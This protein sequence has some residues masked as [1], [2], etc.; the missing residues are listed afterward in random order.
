[1]AAFASAASARICDPMLPE[2]AVSFATSASEAAHVVSGFAVAYGLLQ[3]FFGPLGDRVGKYR[4]IALATLLSA[5]G[6]LAATLAWSLNSLVAARILTGATAA[7]IIPLSMAWI[8]DT[9][10]YEDRQATLA[11]FLGGQILGVVGGQFIG[12]LFADTLGWRFAFAFLALIYLVIGAAVWRESRVNAIVRQTVVVN[13]ASAGVVPQII[14]VLKMPWARVVL[15]VVFLEGML[16]FGPLAFVPSFLHGSFGVSLTLAGLLMTAFGLGGLTY[17]AFARRLVRRLGEVGLAAMGGVLL[18]AAWSLLALEKGWE[19]TPLAT[20]LIGLG[21]YS[22][23]N[24]LQTNATQMAPLVRGTAVSLFASALFIGQS[25]G[26]W[27][28]AQVLTAADG[29]ALFAGAALLTP[30]VAAV[31][32]ALLSRHHRAN[33]ARPA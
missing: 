3:A 6:A 11:R 13:K 31:F 8:G 14:L 19:W 26:V 32:A 1:M 22:L 21:Y 24:T 30:V 12:G 33:A 2:L 4:L 16:V 20:Y 5:L 9:V 17:I 18:A 10:A 27:T 28:A 7:G 23:H 25:L 29:R 15:A